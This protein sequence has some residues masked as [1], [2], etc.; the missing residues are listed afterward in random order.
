M[1][2]QCLPIINIVCVEVSS[3]QEAQLQDISEENGSKKNQNT[4]GEKNTEFNMHAS[5][6]FVLFYVLFV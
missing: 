1:G 5:K 4:F 2:P 6:T 3:Q